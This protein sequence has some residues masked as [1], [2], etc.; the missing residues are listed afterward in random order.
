MS[1]VKLTS[2]ISGNAW[3]SLSVTIMPSIVAWNRRSIL[4]DVLARPGIV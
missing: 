2:M 3:I 1:A 4:L